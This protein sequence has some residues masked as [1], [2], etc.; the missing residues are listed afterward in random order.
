MLKSLKPIALSVLL[1]VVGTNLTAQDLPQ[2]AGDVI[3]TITG[4]ITNTNAGD[5]A[6]FDLQML[7]ALEQRQTTTETP[8]YDGAQEF[9]GPTLATLLEHVGATGSSLRI[10]AVNDYAAEMPIEDTTAAPVILASRHQ[11]KPMPLREK[12]PLFV[13]YPFSEMPNLNNEVYFNRSVWQVKAIE[14]LP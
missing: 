5:A 8:W 12:G 3:L 4:A 6:T 14:V 1:A 9:S 11:G 10:V 13:I 2:P 7:D